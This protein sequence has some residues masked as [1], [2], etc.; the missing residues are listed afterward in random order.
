[1]SLGFNEERLRVIFTDVRC[2]WN[3]GR[4]PPSQRGQA[5]RTYRTSENAELPR[6]FE[7]ITESATKE[8]TMRLNENVNDS[9][10]DSFFDRYPDLSSNPVVPVELKETAE[11]L[12]EVF[13]ETVEHVSKTGSKIARRRRLFILFYLSESPDTRPDRA[14]LAKILSV[15][16]YA[17]DEILRYCRKILSEK[18][19]EKGLPPTAYLNLINNL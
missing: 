7:V 3:A 14:Q 17:V 16:V 2:G 11:L 4:N 6:H 5:N 12:S 15:S 13:N 1:M 9:T 18:C 8:N 10:N 19:V